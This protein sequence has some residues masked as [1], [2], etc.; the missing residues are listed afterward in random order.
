MTQAILRRHEF[1]IR[2]EDNGTR[3]KFAVR[4]PHLE[5]GQEGTYD[6]D[7]YV[8]VCALLE[9]ASLRRKKMKP[10]PLAD[11]ESDPEL[12]GQ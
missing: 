10:K 2:V 5:P 3:L 4:N 1:I 7:A 9:F 6:V 12:Y 8:A 11:D